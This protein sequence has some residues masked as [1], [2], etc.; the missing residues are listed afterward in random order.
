MSSINTDKE[1]IIKQLDENLRKLKDWLNSL[2]IKNTVLLDSLTNPSKLSIVISVDDLGKYIVK[3]STKN[4][5]VN[6]HVESKVFS[7]KDG[8]W[9]SIIIAMS[10]PKQKSVIGG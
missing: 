5:K 10:E 3:E 1:V 2:G 7:F 8:T 6:I 4:V 9:L